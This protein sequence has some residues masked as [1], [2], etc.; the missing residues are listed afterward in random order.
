MS[1]LEDAMSQITR[2]PHQALVRRS[3][4]RQWHEL[5]EYSSNV[6]PVA[7]P[8]IALPFKEREIFS[9]WPMEWQV[10]HSALTHDVYENRLLKHFLWRQLLPRLDELEKRAQAEIERRKIS[11]SSAKRSGWD[12]TAEAERSQIVD[13]EQVAHCVDRCSVWSSD[14]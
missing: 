3:E 7:G 14:G 10:E 12:D 8:A 13:L 9:A 1:D 11:L 6:I 5:V 2:T 4:R